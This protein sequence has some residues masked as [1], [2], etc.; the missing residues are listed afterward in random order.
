MFATPYKR[1][2]DNLITIMSQI[3]WEESKTLNTTRTKLEAL[4]DFPCN[5]ASHLVHALVQ[6]TQVMDRQLEIQ[7]SLTQEIQALRKAH[8]ELEEQHFI[9]QS[10]V[11][12]SLSGQW[13][14]PYP[15]N[16][17]VDGNTPFLCSK[18]FRQMLGFQNE[19]EFP[20]VLSSWADRIHPDDVENVLKV[21]NAAIH[22]KS[23]KTP[24]SPTY[25]LK[26]KAGEY[27]YYH[28][29][30]NIT[31][32]AQGNPIFMAGSC[33]DIDNEVRHK[34]ELD[35]IVERFNLALSLI[36][37]RIFDLRLIEE[38]IFSSRNLCWFSPRLH[39]NIVRANQASI[40]ALLECVTPESKPHF[41]GVLEKLTQELKQDQSIKP[42]ELE[43]A[44]RASGTQEVHIYKFQAT[45]L[46]N[47]SNNII[48]KRI[49]GV[50]TDIDAQK[51]QE[52]FLAKEE[53]FNRQTKQNLDNIAGII[54]KIDGIAKQTNLLALNAAIE[55]AR[56]GEHGRGFAVVADE[57][58]K[59][60]SK[61]S[62][63]TNEI[64]TLLNSGHP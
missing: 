9:S 62:E 14:M 18:R 25:R 60:A 54:S 26:N 23:G 47:K 3:K 22:D 36:S 28:A 44:L 13:Y 20:S 32:D 33:E 40:Q 2:L 58:S 57:V 41:L 53:E 52:E 37:D 50:L 1:F 19:Q 43:I 31:R 6:F 10:M 8:K 56:A 30:G 21:R 34:M 45:A 16:G 63:A 38:D 35:N 61:T 55:A 46:K 49:V 7:A 39:H 15:A 11:D 64:G 27:R 42:L 51:K 48:T 5:Q 24:Y 29:H 12:T 4:K 17:Q 59:L